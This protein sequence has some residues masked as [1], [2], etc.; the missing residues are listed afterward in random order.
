MEPI[1]IIVG[2]DGTPNAAHAVRWAATYAASLKARVLVAYAF[3]PPVPL[4]PPATPALPAPYDSAWQKDLRALLE[5]EW[6]TPLRDADVEYE[7]RLIAGDPATALIDLAHAEHASFIVV[8]K[9]GRNVMADALLGSVS[10][11]LARHAP[12]PLVI[13][14]ADGAITA[15]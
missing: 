6:C 11:R 10:H 7:P 2:V 14:P 5:H 12:C 1:T 9:R 8:G 4:L 13:I 3:E 15:P